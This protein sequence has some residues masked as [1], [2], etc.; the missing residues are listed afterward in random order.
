VSQSTQAGTPSTPSAK[1]PVIDHDAEWLESD[2]LGGFASGPVGTGRTRRYHALLLTAA[3]PPTGRVV[4]VN[5]V[6]AHVR[7]AAAETP[8]STNS[9]LPD[10]TYPDGASHITDFTALPWPTWRFALPGGALVQQEICVARDTGEVVLRWTASG[11]TGPCL[12]RVR[13]LLTGRDFHSLHRENAGFDFGVH[14]PGG[15]ASGNVAIRAYPGVPAVAMLSNATYRHAPEWFRNLL[16]V[17]ERARGLDAVEDVASP[18]EFT[19]D[20]ASGE[21]VLVLRAGDGAFPRALPTARMLLAAERARRTAVTPLDVAAEAYLVARTA[22]DGTEGAT[23]IAGFP[24]F[25]DW[26]RD[27]FIAMRGLVLA[28]G[29]LDVAENILAAWADTVSEGMVPNRFLDAGEG[30]EF[31]SVDASLW[32]VIV[33][34]EFLQACAKHG[35]T[36]CPNVAARLRDAS[37]AILHAYMHGTRHNIGTDTDGLV[38]AGV[39]GL[40]LTWMDA[41]VGDWVVTPRIGKPVEIQALWIN[42]LRIGAGWNAAWL[43]AEARARASF[44]ARFPRPD[45]LGL[46]DVVDDGHVP[47]ADDARIRPNQIF[48]VGGLPLAV[49]E[50]AAA[51][52]VV[53]V[54]SEQLLTPMGLR[55]LSPDHPE[56][57]PHYGGDQFHRDGAYHQG[58]VWPWLMGPFVEAWLR[59]G[60]DRAAAAG[61][62]A[63]LRAHLSRAGIGHVSE[64]ADG[65]APHKPGGCPFQAWS[66]GELIRIEKELLF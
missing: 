22:S 29:K 32:F 49:L 4:L 6:E 54:V 15:P 26:G 45:G 40:Q 66:L 61:F 2:G 58:T 65:D 34:H 28:R 46:F 55:T 17:E 41:K 39:P 53:K 33:A 25:A 13:P 27:T 9:Y 3:S 60:G 5:G 7:H 12:L 44:L 47:G 24:W 19:W 30:A 14:Q 56:Y 1:P 48:A 42:A 64:V 57:Q 37:E 52:R 10:V 63:P 20:L 35:R 36:P 18:G 16:Y 62:V 38:H 8:L 59:A 23:L 31:N 11:T 43:D 50:G 21:A 51:K